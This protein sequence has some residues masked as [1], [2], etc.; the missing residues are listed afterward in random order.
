MDP[1]LYHRLS[2]YVGATVMKSFRY[3]W[4]T[5]K[6][7]SYFRYL[8]QVTD[9]SLNFIINYLPNDDRHDIDYVNGGSIL[10]YMFSQTGKPEYQSAADTI[11]K[12]LK[13]FSRFSDGGFYH[14]DQPVMQ[15]DDLY[16]GAPFL[17]EYGQVFNSAEDYDIAIQQA[18][19]MEKFT[20]D[21]ISGLYHHAW[22]GKDSSAS[23][24]TV[25]PFF[26]GRGMGW[27]VMALVDM[28]DFLP[29]DYT[30]RDSVVAVFQRL[31]EAIAEVQ[32]E[33][34]GIWWQIVDQAERYGNFKESSATC[35]F[36]YALAKG[37]RKGYI[38][39]SFWIVVEKGYRGI[40]DNFIDEKPDGTF[41]ITQNCPGQS[42]SYQYHAYTQNISVEA[43]AVGPF[44][45]ASIEVEKR[46]I[47]PSNLVAEVVSGH[48]VNLHWNDN[49]LNE[50]GFIVERSS[51]VDFSELAILGDDTESYQDTTVKPLTAY[52]YRIRTYKGD[53]ISA[54]SDYS[55]VITMNEN[56][57]PAYASHP[58]PENEIRKVD[59]TDTL[60]WLPGSGSTSHDVFFGKTNPP[61]LVKNQSDSIFIPDSL[62]HNT[63]Y[64]WQINEKNSK[65]STQGELWSFATKLEKGL[66]AYWNMDENSGN[67]I[68]DSSG[69]ANTG[70]LFNMVNTAW[71]P[72]ISGNALR[73][74]GIDDF[75]VVPHHHSLD[76]DVEN[77]S[78]SFWL[79]QSV[80]DRKMTYI[81]KGTHAKPGSS[82][83]Y[84]VYFN[85]GSAEISAG[86]YDSFFDSVKQYISK[87]IEFI[88]DEWVHF[89]VVRN[90]LTDKIHLYLNTVE[91][92]YFPGIITDVSQNED[93]YIA[94]S[95]DEDNTCFEGML[96][97][98][99][100][101][102][103]SLG[104]SEI[105]S[106][107]NEQFPSKMESVSSGNAVHGIYNYPN[108]FADRTIIE[109][110]LDR[111]EKVKL[112]IYNLVG[113]EIEVLVN[114]T[115]PGGT[116]QVKFDASRLSN[117]TYIC[118][119]RTESV[120]KTG[121]MVC[122]K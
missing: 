85:K 24:G 92:G 56:G 87:S 40:L 22:I 100:I 48:Q 6:D 84:E 91:T 27:I 8:Q 101:Y 96:D 39:E 41:W 110:N 98:I 62:E 117:G 121:K 109:Y 116:Y 34:T 55:S 25:T 60:K 30:G 14:K 5:T 67:R 47:I 15:V 99:R 7:S 122:F 28:L 79:Y 113:Q 17:A 36:V 16:M 53:T 44:I 58:F 120:L 114:Q 37:I 106:I 63:T 68:Y 105:R 2:D 52:T 75:I 77:F 29:E 11:M 19:Q 65:G 50:D 46:G 42:P 31:A 69:Y 38:D 23:E 1:L 26:W 32:D 115:Q 72:G 78:I 59:P 45:M 89:V 74:D 57:A 73:F 9:S 18:I 35:M 83:R 90:Q 97:E 81:I 49:S 43:H 70:T 93:L 64:Y 76:F 80:A 21:A 94:V 12:Y 95:P 10:L 13:S 61:P 3:L 107:Y 111:K 103:Y 104:L 20:R 102:N 66:V 86:I 108:P 112:A 4:E 88:T 82:R 71:V 33:S 118:Q 54:F 51:G 119:L